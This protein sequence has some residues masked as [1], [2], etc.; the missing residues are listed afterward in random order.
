MAIA[1]AIEQ[2]CYSS[3]LGQRPFIPSGE[4]SSTSHLLR[5]RSELFVLW[6]LMRERQ[7]RITCSVLHHKSSLAPFGLSLCHPSA[8][9]IALACALSNPHAPFS[10]P[11]V[12]KFTPVVVRPHSSRL[13]FSSLYRLAPPATRARSYLP[14][15]RSM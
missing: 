14:R 12:T 5:R 4:H 6:C 9:L 13:L 11:P 15:R 8:V 7:K 3:H 2:R 10:L 1:T